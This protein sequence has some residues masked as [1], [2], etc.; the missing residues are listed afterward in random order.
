MVAAF[1]RHSSGNDSDNQDNSADHG[2]V[3][4]DPVDFEARE[5]N[6]DDMSDSDEFDIE[7]SQ[8]KHNTTIELPNLKIRNSIMT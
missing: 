7:L 5:V 2:H 4:L 3:T 8:S 6:S 1:K